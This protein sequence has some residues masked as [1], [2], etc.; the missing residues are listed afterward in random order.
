MDALEIYARRNPKLVRFITGAL[1]AWA[2]ADLLAA[3]R[4]H[5]EARRVVGELQRAASESL[6]G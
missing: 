6:G 1:V 4:L 2:A 3:V 5:V